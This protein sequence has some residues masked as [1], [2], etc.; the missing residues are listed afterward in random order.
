MENELLPMAKFFTKIGERII[1]SKSSWWHEVQ[2]GVLLSFPYYNIIEPDQTEIDGLFQKHKLRALR[3]PTPLESFGFISTV[4]LN[5]NHNYNLGCLHSAARRQTKQGLKNCSIEQLDF[6]Y[7]KESG[8]ILNRQTTDRQG[9][10]S[11]YNDENYWHQYCQAAKETQ[12]CIA[13][14]AKVE[15]NLG[16]FLIAIEHDGWLNCL[17]TNSSSTLLKK[18][19]SNAL[20][21]EVSRYYLQ[22]RNMNICY[23]IG[24][25]E[26]IPELDR[27][28]IRMDWQLKPIKQRLIF[29]KKI[30]F[31][32]SFAQEPCL[33]LLNKAFPKNYTIRKTSSMIRLYRQQTLK[34]PGNIN[35]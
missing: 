11:F 2:N 23:G 5:T 33:N 35:D 17:L 15:G 22:E 26:N 28:K 1:S 32:F 9:R 29:S 3:Y 10:D 14:G 12:G 19:P 4:E 25:L 13:W 6:D 31:A 21:F 16:S 20:I 30:Q 7:L 8:L 24:S 27:F 18:R 34:V